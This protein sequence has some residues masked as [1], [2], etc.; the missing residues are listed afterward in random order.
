MSPL[1]FLQLPLY[2]ELGETLTP[3]TYQGRWV[4]SS[5]MFQLV[6]VVSDDLKA[7]RGN[8]QVNSMVMSNHTQHKLVVGAVEEAYGTN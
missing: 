2:S 4:D 8:S 3:G 7:R 1:E 5:Y 6:R